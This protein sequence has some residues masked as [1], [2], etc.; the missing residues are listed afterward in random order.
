MNIIHAYTLFEDQFSGAKESRI[1]TVSQVTFD[2]MI[3]GIGTTFSQFDKV[4]SI[5]YN[6]KVLEVRQALN[7]DYQNN[8]TN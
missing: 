8:R 7:S 5:R 3:K 4:Q 2:K 6:W 1:V